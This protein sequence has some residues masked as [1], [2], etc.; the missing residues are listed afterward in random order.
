MKLFAFGVAGAQAAS[1]LCHSTGFDVMLSESDVFENPTL[2]TDEQRLWEV[3]VGEI[4]TV[5]C[6]G[7]LADLGND[8]TTENQVA[9]TQA[10]NDCTWSSL[11]I[12]PVYDAVANTF[13]YTVSAGVAENP[14][15]DENG[16]VVMLTRAQEVEITCVYDALLE[17]QYDNVQVDANALAPELFTIP[18]TTQLWGGYFAL[19]A[20][21]DDAH[22]AL[23]TTDNK[24]T[25]GQTVYNQLTEIDLPTDFNWYVK[26][27]I[28]SSDDVGTLSVNLFDAYE[29]ANNLFDTTF[30]G[31]ALNAFAL[32]FEFDF[33]SFVFGSDFGD[34]QVYLTCNVQVCPATEFCGTRAALQTDCDA[35]TGSYTLNPTPA[36]ETPVA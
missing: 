3:T 31:R 16:V 15:I 28:A 4:N 36:V 17:I 25:L 8:A 24:I 19:N 30:S 5:T 14:T 7:A 13:T 34:S 9:L 23:I 35:L 6:K 12:D 2:L 29:C 1:I 11:Q 27:C 20:Y 21:T 33:Q 18:D 32:P 26:S 10:D 22:T